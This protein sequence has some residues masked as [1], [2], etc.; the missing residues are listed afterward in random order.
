MQNKT[1][2]KRANSLREP[3]L[4][5]RLALMRYARDKLEAATSVFV[6]STDKMIGARDTTVRDASRQ[7]EGQLD[8]D[9][10][11][12]FALSATDSESVGVR[13]EVGSQLTALSAEPARICPGWCGS[14]ALPP[15][16]THCPGLLR[17]LARRP[18]RTG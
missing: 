16:P 13:R 3:K 6:L 18:G 10:A 11:K 1:G 15:T 4:A 17:L 9:T 5:S 12:G 14:R 7:A 8:A 2:A